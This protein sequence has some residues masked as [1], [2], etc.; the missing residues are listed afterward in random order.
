MSTKSEVIE[1]VRELP[2]LS[3]GDIVSMMPHVNPQTV[4][5]SLNSLMN[6][7]E[8]RREGQRREE[9]RWH[10][11]NGV[12]PRKFSPP[13]VTSGAHSKDSE[14]IVALKA[15]IKELETWKAEAI[16]RYPDLAIPPLLKRAR[17]IVASE[18][19]E[20]G[21]RNGA[22]DVEK[23]ARDGTLPVRLVLKMLEGEVA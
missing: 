17:E 20:S 11:G 8:L 19:R 1:V 21:D 2:G 3:S 22:A 16:Q 7:G 15:Q 18:L 5:A 23:G 12:P 6:R 9:Y 10:L 13:N 4:Y 14:I